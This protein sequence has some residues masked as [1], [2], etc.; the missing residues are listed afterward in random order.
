MD[1]NIECK[2]P[3][4]TK[5]KKIVII[6]LGKTH[7]KMLIILNNN[8]KIFLNANTIEYWGTGFSYSINVPTH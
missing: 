4:C 5:A 1:C 6:D 8:K 2:K 3:M 7:Q